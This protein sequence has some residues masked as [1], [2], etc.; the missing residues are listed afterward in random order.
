MCKMCGV[1][2]KY[3]YDFS[4]MTRVVENCHWK[5][6]QR[7]Q[8]GHDTNKSNWTHGI[9]L[10]CW[11]NQ[12]DTMS[13]CILIYNISILRTDP[14]SEW[15]TCLDWGCWYSQSPWETIGHCHTWRVSLIEATS[16]IHQH[17]W[18]ESVVDSSG[19]LAGMFLIDSLS[20]FVQ[21][22]TEVISSSSS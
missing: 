6:F 12:Q 22:G 19:F 11:F 21:L 15:T 9:F 17:R 3:K 4:F 1:F 8:E 2:L 10:R 5:M 13:Q 16:C 20:F 18:R 14:Y 7:T